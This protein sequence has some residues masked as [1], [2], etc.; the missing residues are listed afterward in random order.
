MVRN[1]SIIKM[2]RESANVVGCTGPENILHALVAV[3]FETLPIEHQPTSQDMANYKSDKST[4]F[5]D[6]ING[7]S[8]VFLNT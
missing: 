8:S 7:A 3:V 2:R 5:M 6:A 1:M 4:I